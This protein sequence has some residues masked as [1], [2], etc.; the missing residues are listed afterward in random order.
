MPDRC[1]TGQW[2]VIFTLLE[3]AIDCIKMINFREESVFIVKAIVFY[4]IFFAFNLIVS[5][6]TKIPFPL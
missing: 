2:K 1:S 3:M 6:L 5:L 4:L